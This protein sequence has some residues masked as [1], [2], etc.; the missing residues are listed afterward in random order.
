MRPIKTQS[1]YNNNFEAGGRRKRSRK[2]KSVSRKRLNN[3]SNR[4]IAPIERLL[5]KMGEHKQYKRNL[6]ANASQGDAYSFD[7][8]EQDILDG[9]CGPDG[10]AAFDEEG[11]EAEFIQK[12]PLSLRLADAIAGFRDTRQGWMHNKKANAADNKNFGYRDLDGRTHFIGK[13]PFA[14]ARYKSL[15]R[16]IARSE[17]R[18]DYGRFT[19]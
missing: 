17:G 18:E 12:P 16:R 10:C 8:G 9:D 15:Q 2:L 11:G 1:S 5:R 7:D 19:G 3:I 6:E 13:N 4:Q 14:R